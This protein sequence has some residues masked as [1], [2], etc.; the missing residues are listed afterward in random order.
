MEN[1]TTLIEQYI[2]RRPDIC[3]GKPCF[4]GTRM[5]VHMVLEMLEGGASFEEIMERY[6]DL[7]P[8]HIKAALEYAARVLEY[9]E[10]DPSFLKTD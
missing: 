7:S 1:Q 5:M 2:W 9:R 10:F 4:K 3:H 8:N 6:P